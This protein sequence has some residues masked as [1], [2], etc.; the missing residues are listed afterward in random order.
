MATVSVAAEGMKPFKEFWTSSIWPTIHGD[1]HRFLRTTPTRVTEREA[2]KKQKNKAEEEHEE[3]S[4]TQ[5]KLRDIYKETN[6]KGQRRNA[7]LNLA[8]TGP[9]EN[10]P[11]QENISTEK[12]FRMFADMFLDGAKL[13]AAQKPI[14]GDEKQGGI[15][16]SLFERLNGHLDSK[17]FPWQIPKNVEKGFEISIAV[18]NVSVIP[19]LGKFERL[20]MDGAVNA[21]WSASY[22]AKVTNDDVAVASLTALI[23]EWPMDFIKIEGD[24]A[25]EQQDNKFKWAINFSVK[26]ERL[27]DFIGL[28]ASN[29]LRIVAHAASIVNRGTKPDAAA[30]SAWLN[31]HI[32][33]GTFH[34]PDVKTIERHLKNWEAISKSKRAVQ[35]LDAATQRWGR[36]NLLDWPTKLQ[37][38]VS[39]SAGDTTMLQ[40]LVEQFFVLMIRTQEK[41]PMGVTELKK[42]ITDFCWVRKYFR[43]CMQ[44]Y[45]AMFQNPDDGNNEVPTSGAN[46]IKLCRHFHENPYESFMKTESTEKDATWIQALPNEPLRAFIQ[47]AKDMN[48]LHYKSEIRSLCELTGERKQNSELF[49][50][51]SR[52]GAR[53]FDPFDVAYRTWEAISTPRG[54]GQPPPDLDQTSGVTNPNPAEAQKTK[55]EKTGEVD[56]PRR[57]ASCVTFTSEGTCIEIEKIRRAASTRT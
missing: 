36:E 27:R 7:N 20:A 13:Q 31:E 9:I 3:E 24:N 18:T 32:K 56:E 47:H 15:Q 25:Q 51:G 29:L 10:T 6:E 26:A 48:A 4:Y 54:T 52:V 17:D 40:F 46:P 2:G 34:C 57:S 33:W 22:L 37:E 1:Y 14:D 8:F 49:H 5:S 50:K 53:F 16:K 39:R 12:V 28:E 55:K 35:L 30:V 43:L 23:L 45:A 21:V 44:Q 42:T 41:D 38:I 19:E 11:L